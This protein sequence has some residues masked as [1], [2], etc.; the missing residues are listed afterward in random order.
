ML[1]SS[2]NAAS[3]AEGRPILVAAAVDVFDLYRA[4]LPNIFS[5]QLR[6]VP[7]LAMQTY[8]D[9]LHLAKATED[10]F[11][12]VV[13]SGYADSQDLATRLR[14]LG[15]WI[16]ETSLSHQRDLLKTTLDEAGGFLNTAQEPTFKRCER[17][18][19]EVVRNVENI[20]KMLRV[21]LPLT[22][23]LPTLGYLTEQL[24]DL[25][26]A[27]IL[28][29]TDITEIES[30]K[31]NE[32]L[33]LFRPLETIFELSSEIPAETTT[34]QA[35]GGVAAHV[36]SWLKMSYLSELL[37]ASLVDIAYLFET[38][39]LIDYTSEELVGLIMA[40]FADSEKRDKTIE[41]IERGLEEQTS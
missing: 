3:F 1:T 11:G 23:Y 16:Y 37:R 26:M 7:A 39:A 21:V 10:F 27:D 12:D 33:D 31:I 19:K 8:N 30:E 25:V 40:L 14:G 32:L 20:A 13:E 15:K 22:T 2:L 18:V 6:D 41:R 24:I 29:L 17:A 35:M 5:S 34:L 4:L 36:P 28:A 9:C 38:G